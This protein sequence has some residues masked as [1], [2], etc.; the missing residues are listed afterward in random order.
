QGGTDAAAYADA[1]ATYLGMGVSRLTDIANA[2]TRW[3]NTKEQVR[4]LFGRQAIPMIWDF[5]EPPPFGKAAGSYEV[6]LGNLV[7]ALERTPA[8]PPVASV[9]QADAASRA[10]T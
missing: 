7:K 8:R 5:G 10:Y 9:Q 1:V 3:E 6:S 2:L 4:N